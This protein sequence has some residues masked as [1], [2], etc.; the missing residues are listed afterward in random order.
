MIH[1]L[2]ISVHIIQGEGDKLGQTDLQRQQLREL[3]AKQT[4]QRQ[5][6]KRLEE[7]RMRETGQMVAPLRHW[8]E[9]D[10][11]PSPGEEL[12]RQ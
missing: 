10:Q 12:N 8:S 2:H 7:E 4:K 1:D 3:L 9:G 5:S 6:K 11:Y